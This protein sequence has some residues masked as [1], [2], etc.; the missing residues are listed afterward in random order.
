MDTLASK[1]PDFKEIVDI[2]NGIIAQHNEDTAHIEDTRKTSFV[3]LL[4]VLYRYQK[5]LRSK[6]LESV[7]CPLEDLSEELAVLCARYWNLT[8]AIGQT[9]RRGVSSATEETLPLVCEENREELARVCGVETE[10][11][12][13]TWVSEMQEMDES[14]EQPSISCHTPDF[15]ITVDRTQSL[16]LVT[17]LGTRMFP[18]PS[19][20]DVVMDLRAELVP[21]LGGEA[22]SGMV[23]GMR[24]I[25]D[26]SFP[27]LKE[28]LEENPGYSILV[29][30]YSLG[31]GLAQ[32]YAAQLL[33]S[34]EIRSQLPEDI[35]IRALCYGAPP[36][37]R[38]EERR[39]FPEI[40]I[41]Q[42]DKD[43]IISVST[44]NAVD[45]F[46]TTVAIDAAD[47]DTEVMYKMIF[48]KIPE[49]EDDEEDGP[50]GPESESSW[51]GFKSIVT[52]SLESVRETF[53]VDPEEWEKVNEAIRNRRC[54]SHQEMSLLGKTV[55][56][57]KNVGGEVKI[58]KFCGI[59]ATDVLSRELRLS[60]L[61][62]DHH[63][64]WGYTN[65]FNISD[66]EKSPDISVLD[67]VV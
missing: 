20:Y 46:N 26:K 14:S 2:F 51:Q 8:N 58:R 62:F 39:V 54:H 25:M 7:S 34:E 49:D 56:Q 43:G 64:P 15:T 3:I 47:I 21:F 60:K 48:E 30:G 18:N 33:A 53:K 6:E 32:L 9:L 65:L 11:V 57:M 52:N 13:M 67:S 17:I 10:D 12:V 63:M 37:F 40:V 23:I 22:H 41:V 28:T 38:S 45:L 66:T 42:N 19:V 55:L 1:I 4:G 61:M 29:V 16:V 59:D 36:I 24:N 44:K 35:V 50:D 27:V 5:R 31:S